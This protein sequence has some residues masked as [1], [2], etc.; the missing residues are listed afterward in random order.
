MIKAVQNSN[1]VIDLKYQNFYPIP[2]HFLSVNQIFDLNKFKSGGPD[3]SFVFLIQ[4]L[5]FPA[6]TKDFASR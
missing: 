5:K 1:A 2:N 4:T 6:N 3:I